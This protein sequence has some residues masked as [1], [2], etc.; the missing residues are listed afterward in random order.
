[1]P[2]VSQLEE[3]VR[4]RLASEGYVFEAN[5]SD[6]AGSPDV[7]FRDDQVALFVDGCFWHQH[8]GCPSSRLPRTRTI[9][10]LARLNAVVKRDEDVSAQ[11]EADGWTV[12]RLWE[13]E[14]Q[15]DLTVAS[16]RLSA[17]G[18]VKPTR[19]FGRNSSS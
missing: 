6:V 16:Q 9:E 19:S 14:I 13:C 5:C 8:V 18:C 1:M 3:R 12:I 10:W 15:S 7:V 4:A 17:H 11:L 2:N